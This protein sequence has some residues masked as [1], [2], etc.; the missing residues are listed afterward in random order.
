MT[1]LSVLLTALMARVA[2]PGV[3]SGLERL[4]GGANMESFAFDWAGPDL[5]TGVNALRASVD[6]PGT[7]VHIH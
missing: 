6:N 3:L 5:P 4:S 7:R 2:G 1:S